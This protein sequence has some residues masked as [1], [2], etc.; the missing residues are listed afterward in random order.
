MM[1]EDHIRLT[2]PRAIVCG[3][4][5]L[6]LTQMVSPQGEVSLVCVCCDLLPHR[7]PKDCFHRG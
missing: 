7:G 1:P 6:G 4:C 2:I 3:S 5:G